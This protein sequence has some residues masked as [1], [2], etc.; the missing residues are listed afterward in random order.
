VKLVYR[1]AGIVVIL[2]AVFLF[3]G[4]IATLWSDADMDTWGKAM[5]GSAFA[6]L[7]VVTGMGGWQLLRRS[8]A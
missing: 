4:G 2:V 8:R 1:L 5:V 6:A 7:G 3:F